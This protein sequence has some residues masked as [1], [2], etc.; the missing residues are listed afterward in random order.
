MGRS[1]QA[2]EKQIKTAFFP[3]IS[4]SIITRIVN[5]Y[6]GR[7]GG[8]DCCK[9]AWEEFVNDVVEKCTNLAITTAYAAAGLPSFIYEWGYSY[10]DGEK[11]KSG[12]ASHGAELSFVWGDTHTAIDLRQDDPPYP[13]TPKEQR[14]A[15][16]TMAYWASFAAI[17]DPNAASPPPGSAHWPAVPSGPAAFNSSFGFNINDN[18][19]VLPTTLDG[20]VLLGEV[21]I[22]PV[23][24]PARRWTGFVV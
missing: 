7:F 18:L 14:L 1:A 19:G 22:F 4:D 15:N 11:K 23:P 21:G 10:N 12:I 20:C 6:V 8:K 9:L 17:H 2:L 5:Y 16:Q 13:F 3:S 24:A